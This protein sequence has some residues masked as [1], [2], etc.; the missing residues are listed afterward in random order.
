M[1]RFRELIDSLSIWSGTFFV[2]LVSAA[3]VWLLARMF[4]KLR[5]LWIVIVPF[6]IAFCL[7][8]SP[9][10]LGTDPS[11]Y[12][13]WALV[14]IVPWFLAGAIASAAVVRIFHNRRVR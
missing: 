4:T 2:A 3:V 7:Y 5:K 10:W 6:T 13:A 14:F 1:Q 11:E 12:H 9:V 8:W